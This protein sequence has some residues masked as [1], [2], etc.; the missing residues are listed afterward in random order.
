M[1]AAT[2]SLAAADRYIA[3]ERNAGTVRVGQVSKEFSGEA[4]FAD[5]VSEYSTC[6]WKVLRTARR[7]GALAWLSITRSME[8]LSGRLLSKT[9]PRN[10]KPIPTTIGRQFTHH[11]V[12]KKLFLRSRP[13]EWCLPLVHVRKNPSRE[14]KDFS[15]HLVLS[16][17]RGRSKR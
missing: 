8:S 1:S 12:R 3:E 14:R 10:H 15:W 16:L 4:S 11:K 9:R 2:K 17:E 7:N 6:R 13:L 5:T